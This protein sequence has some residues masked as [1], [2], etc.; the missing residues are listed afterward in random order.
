MGNFC[1][2]ASNRDDRHGNMRKT[3]LHPPNNKASFLWTV[4]CYIV[5]TLVSSLSKF[6]IDKLNKP[7][8]HNGEQFLTLLEKRPCSRGLVTVSNHYSCMDDPFIW[9]IRKWKHVAGTKYLR[10]IPTA[11]NI[12]FT[13]YISTLFFSLGKCVPVVRGDGVYQRGMDFCLDKLNHGEW[14]HI[15]PEGKVNSQHER[16]RLKWGVGRL[17][18]ES[19]T[20]PIVLPLYHMG[21]DNVLPNKKPYIPQIGKN[22]TILVGDPVDYTDDLVMLKNLNKTPTEQRKYITDDIQARLYNLRKITEQMHQ[23]RLGT[24]AR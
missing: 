18:A 20:P 15:F 10:W 17:V 4:S 22:V 1:C 9:S 16:M 13:N 3:W 8:L 11:D 24:S 6:W 23:D 14:V 19:D 2:G 5:T 12:C 7:L 21:F